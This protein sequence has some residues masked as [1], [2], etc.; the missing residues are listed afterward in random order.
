MRSA[1][2]RDLGGGEGAG[3]G[4]TGGAGLLGSPG[5]SGDLSTVGAGGTHWRPGYQGQRRFSSASLLNFSLNQ[6][7]TSFLRELSCNH[8]LRPSYH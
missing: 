8:L 1:T 2:G 5:D 4:L 7:L 6:L 3:D